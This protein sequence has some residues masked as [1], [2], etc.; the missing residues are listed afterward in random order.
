MYKKIAVWLDKYH[1]E[2]DY[3]GK[4]KL[5]TL[6]VANMLPVVKYLAKTIA[7]R[8]TDPIE[9]LVQAGSVGLLKAIEK[10]SKEKNDNFRVYAG[11]LI[12]GEM[13][14]FLRDKLNTIRVPRHIQELCIRIN[15]F[16]NSLTYE[17]LRDLT[18]AEVATALDV[19]TSAVDFALM[20]DRRSSTV[21]L[22]DVFSTS[23]DS[24][25]YEELL[26]D[27]NYKDQIEYEDAKIIFDGVINKLP[28]DEQVIIDMYY[29]QDMNKKEIAE[30]LVMSPRMVTLKMKNAL[31]IISAFI[32]ETSLKREKTIDRIK[33]KREV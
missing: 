8:S 11:Y 18:S 10:Y 5:K 6:I 23:N 30:A 31:E 24:L 1:A 32:A 16:T 25:G 14:H 2:D 29:K 22:E 4:A 21:S 19:P 27:E 33:N 28:P 15:N 9:D 12:I 13:K 20:A 26:L 7:R 3:K 17:Q